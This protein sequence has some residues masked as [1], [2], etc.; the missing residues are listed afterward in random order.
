M[1]QLQCAKGLAGALL[2]LRDK[3]QEASVHEPAARFA[4]ICHTVT[5]WCIGSGRRPLRP[6]EGAGSQVGDEDGRVGEEGHAAEHACFLPAL[7]EQEGGAI[8]GQEGGCNGGPLIV[9]DRLRIGQGDV[10]VS[11]R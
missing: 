6:R 8:H 7:A 4:L 3:T 2:R 9:T 5:A 10:I 11:E 1:L